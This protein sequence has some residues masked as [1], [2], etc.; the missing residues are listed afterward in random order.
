MVKISA[1][2]DLLLIS[3]KGRRENLIKKCKTRTAYELQLTAYL[4]YEREVEKS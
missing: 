1:F 2:C 4:A 3:E